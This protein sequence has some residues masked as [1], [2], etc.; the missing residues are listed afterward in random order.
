MV[1]HDSFGTNQNATRIIVGGRTCGNPARVFD[2]RT[3]RQDCRLFFVWHQ[4][5]HANDLRY[6]CDCVN[7]TYVLFI[8]LSHIAPPPLP[9][10]G[11][12][13]AYVFA[14][15]TNDLITQM[16]FG[17]HVIESCCTHASRHTYKSCRTPACCHTYECGMSRI[18]LVS[19]QQH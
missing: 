7:Y 12:K 3:N 18:H 9:G 13:I 6:A 5:S 19:C 8:I 11:S 2:R 1:Q 16:T 14:L 10:Q 17:T 15:G 4:R